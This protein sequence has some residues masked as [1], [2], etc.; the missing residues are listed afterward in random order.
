MEISHPTGYPV[1]VISRQPDIIRAAQAAAAAAAVSLRVLDQADDIR[2]GWLGATTV[3]IGQDMTQIAGWGLA[4]RHQVYLVGSAGATDLWR[5]S[6]PL[7]AAVILLPQGA[8][9]LARVIAGVAGG[10][11]VVLSLRGGSGGVGVS[12][13][14]VGVALAAVKSDRSV[15]LVDGDASG[16]GLDLVMGA[17]TTRGWRWPKLADA[18]GR[19]ADIAA[20]L[21]EVEGVRLLSWGRGDVPVVS[22]SARQ[23]VVD[24]LARHHDLVVIDAGHGDTTA[25][26]GLAGRDLLVSAASVRA[27]AAAR[28]QVGGDAVAGLA[29]TRLGRIPAGDVAQAVGLP[30]VCAVPRRRQLPG[31]A[32]DGLPPPLA[33]VWGKACRVIVAWA[34][35]E[36]VDGGRRRRQ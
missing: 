22:Q 16:G 21:P 9:W 1:V 28:S 29:V 5:W 6:V 31:L 26:T 27:V 15:A 2:S 13:L 20:M 11:G 14:A 35:G 4:P 10:Q 25:W 36:E 30:L 7:A 33:G 17:E 18:A 12:T 24:V 32:D 34:M 19:L 23:A 3:L 8:D